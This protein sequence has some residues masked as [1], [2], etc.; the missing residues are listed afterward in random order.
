MS[1]SINK[2][3]AVSFRLEKD[4]PLARLTTFRIGGPADW[5]AFCVTPEQVIEAVDYCSHQKLDYFVLG[6]GSNVLASDRGFR[7]MIILPRIEIFKIEG[8]TVT[9]GAAYS[10]AKMIDE[11]CAAGL[12]GLEAMAGIAGQVG[13]AIVGNAGAYGQS[14]ADRLIDVDLYHPVHGRYTALPAQLGFKYRHSDLKWSKNIVLSARF[15]LE[16]ADAAALVKKAK[17][18]CDLRWTRHPHED[19]SA[20]C[21]FKNIEDKSAPHGKIPAGQLLDEIGAK[22]IAVGKAG[23]YP[24]HANILINRGGASASDVRKLSLLLKQ[25]VK[26]TY[27]LE[28]SEEVILLGDFS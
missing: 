21:F 11:L 7:G 3:A 12:A 4:Y 1:T 15:K 26:E 25:K 2:D 20:G 28:L 13:G 6:G 23:V 5:V 22:Q 18:I 16:R 14:I 8:E 9:A 17:E 24:N 19:I 10:L 27:G